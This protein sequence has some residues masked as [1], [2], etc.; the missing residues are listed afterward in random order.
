LDGTTFGVAS[1]VTFASA[2]ALFQA[3]P[4]ITAGVRRAV[5]VLPWIARLVTL[6]IGTPLL[7]ASMIGVSAGA[8]WLRYRAPVRDRGRLGPFGRPV[9][10]VPVAFALLVGAA[11]LQ[12]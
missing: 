6:A 9:V 2:Q 10:C 1:A 7:A 8:F 11:C 12:V 3:I 4:L 5:A